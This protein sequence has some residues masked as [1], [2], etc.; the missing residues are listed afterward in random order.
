MPSFGKFVD[1]DFSGVDFEAF[2]TDR[3]FNKD[4]Y[5]VWFQEICDSQGIENQHRFAV[6]T[7]LKELEI[8]LYTP[9]DVA[10]SGIINDL[11]G[12]QPIMAPTELRYRYTMTINF[13]H[14][15]EKYGCFSNFSRHEVDLGGYVW[16]TSE[17]YYQAQ[18]FEDHDIQKRVRNCKGP[19][20]AR[21]MG[22]DRSLP[23]KKNWEQ[24]KDDVMYKVVLA[25]FT[26]HRHIKEILLGTGHNHLVEKSPIDYYWGSGADGTG[27]NKLGRTLMKVREYLSNSRFL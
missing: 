20:A 18:K 16:P 19:G 24:I 14:P 6:A 27:Q 2:Q 13:Y 12:V 25:K 22:R 9:E 15:D 1:G 23:L 17:H 8:L 11:V 26:Q 21:G 7:I 3:E 10:G 4:D 5:R